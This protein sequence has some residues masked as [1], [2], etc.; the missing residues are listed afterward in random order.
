MITLEFT[1]KVNETISLGELASLFENAENAGISVQIIDTFGCDGL[2]CS[3]L[4]TENELN[5]FL[6]NYGMAIEDGDIY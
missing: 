4:G 3:A 5:D 6:E 1:L 2:I